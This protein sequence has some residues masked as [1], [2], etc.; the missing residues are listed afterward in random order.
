MK[1]L[2]KPKALRPG[3]IVA[4]ISLSWGGASIFPERYKSAKAQFEKTFDVKIIEAPNSLKSDEVLYKNPQMR[5]DDLMWAFE[6]KDVKAILTNIG[7][8]DTIRLL[9]LMNETHFKTMQN[10]PKIFLGMSDTTANHFMCLKAGITSFYSPCLMFGYGENGGV[11]D[12]IIQNTKKT[13]FSQIPVG[14]IEESK[15]YI[16]DRVDWGDLTAP[17]R[18]LTPTTPWRYIGG[19]QTVQG[20]LIGGCTDLF[21]FINGTSLWPDIEEWEN[22]ILFLETSED[23]PTPTAILY[24]M[25][26]LGAQGILKKLKGILF[27]R[28]GGE[29]LPTESTQKEE[30][31][32]SYLEYDNVLI[33]AC[34]EFNVNIP[35]VTN[36]DFGHTVPQAIL[37]Y[38]VKAEINPQQKTVSLL[39]SGVI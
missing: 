3:D 29:F 22:T 12:Y 26:N 2:I 21:P 16:V 18:P 15:A 28:P 38:G 36:M 32:K 23:K 1:S 19:T 10:N 35:I 13:L 30:Y 7:G 33:Q 34:K 24:L 14:M 4:T 25:R 31:L 8:D 20:R 6:N 27:A 37:P 11:P 17:L 39:E 9:P 5:L